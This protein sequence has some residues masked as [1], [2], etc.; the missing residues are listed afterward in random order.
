MISIN[1]W[2]A[3]RSLCG[4]RTTLIRCDEDF[5]ITQNIVFILEK[6]TEIH[7]GKTL[8]FGV[9]YIHVARFIDN[10]KRTTFLIYCYFK[11]HDFFLLI[12]ICVVQLL[13]ST[14]LTKR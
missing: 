13:F 9:L 5:M 3:H 10:C 1:Y 12:F 11:W 6:Q 2:T 8:L 7:M 4:T 14:A